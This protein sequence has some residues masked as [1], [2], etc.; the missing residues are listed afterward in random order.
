MTAE[1]GA[2]LDASGLR[3]Q[4]VDLGFDLAI[5]PAK[6]GTLRIVVPVAQS[7][8]LLR[9]IRE[10]PELAMERLVDLTAIDRGGASADL[11]VVYLVAS[12][13]TRT[14]LRIHVPLADLDAEE[15][16]GLE[17][18]AALWPAADWLEREVFDL[19]GIVFRGHPNLRRVLLEADFEGAP[20]RKGHPLR[21]DR[22]LPEKVA[23]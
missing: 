22:P 16:P 3:D 15:G 6:D 11:E 1:L 13:S 12:T 5:E 17:S 21:T 10:Q 2:S 20:L 14:R 23:P 7:A 19:F 4:L 8:A 18:A 9:R